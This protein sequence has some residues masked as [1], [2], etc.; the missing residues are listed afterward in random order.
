MGKKG[1][2]LGSD[3]EAFQVQAVSK[4]APLG[5]VTSRKMFG[6]FGIFHDGAMFGI[7]SGTSLFL[8]VDDTNIAE[9]QD[10]GSKQHAPMP[11]YAVPETI[12]ARKASLHRWALKAIGVA[13]AGAAKKGARKK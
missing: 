3:S 2:R 8:K 6:G 11:Y 12:Y 10:A 7:V 5:G 4:L 9:Y 1:D 13:H